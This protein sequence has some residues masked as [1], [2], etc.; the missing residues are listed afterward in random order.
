MGGE[1]VGWMTTH[2]QC[3]AKSAPISCAALVFGPM[4][5]TWTPGSSHS[6][7]RTGDGLEVAVMTT[8]APRTASSAASTACSEAPRTRGAI[9]WTNA[10]RRG[11]FRAKTRMWANDRTAHAASRCAL[12]CYGVMECG[13]GLDIR[14]RARVRMMV[15]VRLRARVRAGVRARVRVIRVGVG[16][17]FKIRLKHSGWPGGRCRLCPILSPLGVRGV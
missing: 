4:W 12:A 7:A 16:V 10:S 5:F 1:W 15:R 17:R 14:A 3:S 9:S 13:M 8:S 11:L 2:W 6:T